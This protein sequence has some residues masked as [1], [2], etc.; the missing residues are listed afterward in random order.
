MEAEAITLWD[1]LSAPSVSLHLPRFALFLLVAIPLEIYADRKKISPACAISSVFLQLVTG[2][3]GI[4]MIYL[5][6]TARFLP[7][8]RIVIPFW[9][10]PTVMILVGLPVGFFIAGM[11]SLI[12]AGNLH[13][14]VVR[15]IVFGVALYFAS[16]VV[17]TPFAVNRDLERWERK[18]IQHESIP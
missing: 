6:T 9:Y 14:V 15:C 8:D 16:T 13:H 7:G 2:L 1:L 18:Q 10:Y 12:K 5:L 17:M 3:A 4:L 11:R